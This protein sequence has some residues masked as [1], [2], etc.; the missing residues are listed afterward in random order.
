MK[1][2]ASRG[3][4][5]GLRRLAAATPIAISLVAIAASP[6]AVPRASDDAS[7]RPLEP[8]TPS[9]LAALARL[10]GPA[11]VSV[12]G[13]HA[14]SLAA[15][16]LSAKDRRAFSVGNAFFRD[17]WVIAPASAEGRDGL[18]PF[19]NANS[20]SACHMEDGRGSV[21]LDGEAGVGVVVFLSPR[22]ADGE[23]HP[24][25]GGQLHDQAI[26]G[27]APEAAIRLSPATTT[28]RYPDGTP[29]ELVRWDL[30]F[31]NA[32]YG[33]LDEVRRS[34]RIGQQLAG[35]GLLEAIDEATLLALEDPDDRD[36]DGISGR[37]HRVIGADGTIGIGRFGWKASQPTLE[38]QVIA[39]LHEDLGITSRMRPHEAATDA[40]PEALAA[41]S[42][43][44]PEIDDH[45]IGRLAHYCRVLAVP[46]QRRVGDPQVEAGRELFAAIGCTACH[47]PELRT[48]THSPIEAFR[49]VVIRPYT[50][51]LLHDMGEGLADD[52]RDGAATGREW[53]TP[54]L[55][56]LGLLK[57]VNP[58]ARFL[59]DGR[60]ATIEEA[61]LWHGGEA[62]ASRDRFMQL[63]ASER[64]A[65]L[66][67]LESL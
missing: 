44:S 19:F 17:N 63:D 64:A 67:F 60:A 13:P 14:F 7:I 9:P 10:G 18:G 40:Q 30:S 33:P 4:A 25:Y 62:E 8:A 12:E 29:Y 55:W 16:G 47:L 65:V 66:A 28:G 48:G 11:T 20:C 37:A 31:D 49:D 46:A 51:L 50:D 57:V 3:S 42:G 2:A 58:E 54:P 43:G 21:P 5:V 41:P 53:R 24:T 22:E 26:P 36:G 27:V 34:M 6:L 45:K 52:R 32:A 35:V 15:P 56:G 23:P 1:R 39:A 59:H 38:A 61:I